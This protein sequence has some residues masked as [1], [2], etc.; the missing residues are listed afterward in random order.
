MHSASYCHGLKEIFRVL[1]A[2]KSPARRTYRTRTFTGTKPFTQ[3]KRHDD[4]REPAELVAG[5]HSAQKDACPHGIPQSEVSAAGLTVAEFSD[6][7]ATHDSADE[8]PARSPPLDKPSDA[9]SRDGPFHRLLSNRVST[10][11]EVGHTPE[12]P[13]LKDDIDEDEVEAH[14]HQGSR[15]IRQSTSPKGYT[16][17]LR[18]DAR[19]IYKRGKFG[20]TRTLDRESMSSQTLEDELRWIART[21]P[22]P[23][24]I[25]DLLRLL[26]KDRKIKP[27]SRH[28]EALI[29]GNCSAEQGSVDNV[30]SI[31]D[32]MEREGLA[33]SPSIHYAVLT[34]LAVHPD[35]YL[36]T[37]ILQRLAQQ[38]VTIPPLYVQL[39]IVAM[40]REGQLELA[41][42]ELENLQQK[43]TPIETWVWT[44]YIH[45]ICDD[46][47]DFEG[48]L[49][50][51]YKLHDSN[52]PFPRHTLL[53]VLLIASRKGN[54]DNE[55]GAVALTKWIW[56]TY[57]ENMHII[58]DKGICINV[59]HIAAR[60]KDIDLAESVAVVLEY[61]VAGKATSTP[62][63]LVA[64]RTKMDRYRLTLD[65]PE[66]LGFEEFES[67][68]ES[69][70]YEKSSSSYSYA[71]A[72][73]DPDPGPQAATSTSVLPQQQQQQQQS[74]RSPHARTPGSKAQSRR[75]HVNED[76]NN[77]QDEDEDED[78]VNEAR[79]AAFSTPPTY[80]PSPSSHPLPLRELSNQ[81]LD[82]LR[83][84]RQ[85]TQ[86][87]SQSQTTADAD[88]DSDAD[89]TVPVPMPPQSAPE[90]RQRQRQR[91]KNPAVL[92]KFFRE[93]SGL[94]GARFDPMLAL[95]EGWD[96]RKK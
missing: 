7:S 29:L 44:I 28:Y 82:L 91:R 88:A 80:L 10:S 77:D 84:V 49:Q 70:I 78:A 3:H 68:S 67:E 12:E 76:D 36:R 31:M 4:L 13:P 39:N 16:P 61:A 65:S 87:Q 30:K 92:Y 24:P 9:L 81:A 50:L 2:H 74:M 21:R 5:Q 95:K 59:L 25:Q 60:N 54:G 35:T 71:S 58:P 26:V 19:A 57:V 40:I 14:A 6:Q 15:R 89:G 72:S 62:P 22:D 37:T 23:R 33:I 27:D 53:H 66:L 64:P 63:S 94:R 43:G 20:S 18:E 96:W 55:E 11:A 34:V 79:A 93:E 86:T 51:F 83:E 17:F 69:S 56:Y 75:V 32:D 1:A 38:W 47:H 42:V 45:A 52:F 85:Q 46:R 73:A 90:R 41:T 8:A 48:L